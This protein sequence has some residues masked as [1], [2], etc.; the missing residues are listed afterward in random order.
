[1]RGYLIQW[2]Q[3]VKSGTHLILPL[4]QWTHIQKGNEWEVGYWAAMMPHFFPPS[5]DNQSTCAASVWFFPF[6]LSR[7]IQRRTQNCIAVACIIL[8][9]EKQREGKEKANLLLWAWMGLTEDW[10]ASQ[11]NLF[12][13]IYGIL[14]LIPVTVQ[15]MRSESHN[16]MTVTARS[17]S[18]SQNAC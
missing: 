15:I 9:F 1:M 2:P 14:A 4:Q 7:P 6:F 18:G 13:E 12:K 17:P 8:S 11:S 3:S 5:S 16:K 10:K